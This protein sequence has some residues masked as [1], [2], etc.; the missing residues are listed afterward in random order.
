MTRI[1]LV[2]ENP[3]HFFFYNCYACTM[4]VYWI[5]LNLIC[6]ENNI[7][8]CNFCYEVERCEYCENDYFHCRE[9]GPRTLRCVNKYICRS[10]DKD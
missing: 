8:L 9:C 7:F 3:E 6:L 1:E 10:C 5:D 2:D 4:P